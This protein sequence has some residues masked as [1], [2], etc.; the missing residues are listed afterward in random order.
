MALSQARPADATGILLNSTPA[1]FFG[2][3]LSRGD[4]AR[5]SHSAIALPVSF[6]TGLGWRD[7]TTSVVSR[8]FS[9]APASLAWMLEGN[10]FRKSRNRLLSVESLIVG[11][12]VSSAGR[13]SFLTSTGGSEIERSFRYIRLF[14]HGPHT[15]AGFLPFRGRSTAAR[16]LPHQK[17]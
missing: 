7:A 2:R 10:L 11:Q 16:N 5:R 13:T 17:I 14:W 8:D 4:A 3:P 1:L 9:F 6:D 12:I 15:K